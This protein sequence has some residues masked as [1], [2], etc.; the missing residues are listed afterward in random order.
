M[1]HILHLTT[2]H[3]HVDGVA[4]SFVVE[5]CA[6][7]EALGTRIGL[8]FSR[9]E[10][11]S[12]LSADRF[13]RG[14]PGFVHARSPVPT[15]G[16]KSWNIP[17]ARRY[18]RHFNQKMLMQL[19]NCYVARHGAPDILHGHVALETGIAA[20]TL[21]KMH[22]I[23]Y[24]LTEHS[25]EI[26]TKTLSPSDRNVAHSAYANA[27]TVIAVS[28]P[29][30]ERIRAIAPEANVM[31]VGNLVREKVFELRRFTSASDPVIQIVSVSS[32]V[33]GKRI[34]NAIDAIAA[35]PVE[36]RRFVRYHIVGEG[37][38][39]KA[40]EVQAGLAELNV[41]FHG[42][43]PHDDAMQILAAADLLLHP[44]AHETFGIVLVEAMAVGL[45]VI[46]TRCGGPESIVTNDTGILVPVDDINALTRAIQAIV[47][48]IGNWRSKSAQISEYSR[49][50]FHEKA[51]AEKI[52]RGVYDL[53]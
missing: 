51:V 16:F 4:G 10:G 2:W 14:L 1:T 53:Q 38:D 28:D 24:V 37:P 11:L 42:A 20:L 23:P 40:L 18:V 52:I 49:S 48:D 33:E 39:R 50:N 32:L 29:L 21:A 5:Q 41:T 25:S 15:I 9:V 27:R 7:L 8:I 31:V 19:Y 3:P 22:N 17:G 46:A 36:L 43:L 34:R 47:V 45:P 35:L 12:A 30:A 6:A 13:L 26:M 44:S